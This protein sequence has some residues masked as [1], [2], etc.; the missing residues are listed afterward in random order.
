MSLLENAE[1]LIKSFHRERF[2]NLKFSV[3]EISLSNDEGEEYKLPV[4]DASAVFTA[5]PV[6]AERN[7]CQREA[8]QV[9]NKTGMLIIENF[10]GKY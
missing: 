9:W 4:F 7:E 10:L 3:G 5:E 2:E 8:F 1:K 6:N